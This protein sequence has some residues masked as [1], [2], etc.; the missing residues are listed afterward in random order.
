M[1]EIEILDVTRKTQKITDKETA[2]ALAIWLVLLFSAAIIFVIS[3]T[4][5]LPLAFSYFFPIAGIAVFIFAMLFALYATPLPKKDKRFLQDAAA[6]VQQIVCEKF[7][8]ELPSRKS[9]QSY[10]YPTPAT[11]G[12]D[13]VIVR[14]SF[15]DDAIRAYVVEKEVVP[16]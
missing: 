16:V 4:V 12:K 11:M 9:P 1:S 13:A 15:E 2:I 10:L 14:V 8:I 5:K 7:G 6:D 3:V